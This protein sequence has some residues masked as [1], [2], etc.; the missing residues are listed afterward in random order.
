VGVLWHSSGDLDVRGRTTLPG[1]GLFSPPAEQ[2]VTPAGTT[3][4]DNSSGGGP[5]TPTPP[6]QS[7]PAP[8][9][10]TAEVSVPWKLV[11]VARGER[12]I[13]VRYQSCAGGGAAVTH[14]HHREISLE[15]LVPAPSDA[16]ICTAGHARTLSVRLP[17]SL[18]RHKLTHAATP[19]A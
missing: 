13:V 19:T 5:V 8:N 9:T 17:A 15:L 10:A 18:R 16:P 11:S 7:T 6:A 12:E 2:A 3:P 14:L 1:A 4:P